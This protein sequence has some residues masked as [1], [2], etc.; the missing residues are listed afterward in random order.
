[1]SL[2][3]GQAHVLKGLLCI[4][5]MKKTFCFSFINIFIDNNLSHCL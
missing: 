4:F 3:K 2:G 5:D 1:M